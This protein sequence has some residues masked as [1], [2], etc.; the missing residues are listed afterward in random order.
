MVLYTSPGGGEGDKG[1][2]YAW[3]FCLDAA[4]LSVSEAVPTAADA[5]APAAAA[6]AAAGEAVATTTAAA[7]PFAAVGNVATPQTTAAC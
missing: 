4:K 6:A 7:S 5:I 2:M 3:H 1:S